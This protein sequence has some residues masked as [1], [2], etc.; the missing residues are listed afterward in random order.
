MTKATK[1]RGGKGK[2]GR[3]KGGGGRYELWISIQDLPW[4]I[5]YLLVE[6]KTEG[7]GSSSSQDESSACDVAHY[8]ILKRTMRMKVRL[9]SKKSLVK[10]VVT[11]ATNPDEMMAEKTK[12]EEFLKVWARNLVQKR[13]QS[14]SPDAPCLRVVSTPKKRRKGQ[15]AGSKDRSGNTSGSGTD[16]KHS[17]GSID[18]ES[19]SEAASSK[20]AKHGPP[21]SGE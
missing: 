6:R 12:A 18:S 3:G 11:I 14:P 4:L 21:S 5:S 9:N 1:S 2:G 15:A 10:R 7:G 16:S 13:E 17:S 8:D 20:C 19:E